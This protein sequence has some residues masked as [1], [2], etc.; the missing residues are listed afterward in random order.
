MMSSSV[1]NYHQ[2]KDGFDCGIDSANDLGKADRSDETL[3]FSKKYLKSNS[4]NLTSSKQEFISRNPIE[5]FEIE[6]DLTYLFLFQLSF[7]TE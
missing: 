7:E 5:R 4:N 2:I 3:S 1:C 6:L